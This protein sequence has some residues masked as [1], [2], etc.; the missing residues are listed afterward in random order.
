CEKDKQAEF[1]SK[2]DRFIELLHIVEENVRSGRTHATHGCAQVDGGRVHVDV[3]LSAQKASIDRTALQMTVIVGPPVGVEKTP[4]MASEVKDATVSGEQHRREFN[5]EDMMRELGDD[6]FTSKPV[7]TAISVLASKINIIR[8]VLERMHPGSVS[9]ATEEVAEQRRVAQLEKYRDERND[10][11]IR[12]VEMCASFSNVLFTLIWFTIFVFLDWHH[13]SF[14]YAI[15]ILGGL[16]GTLLLGTYAHENAC[17]ARETRRY[18][19][20]VLFGLFDIAFVVAIPLAASAGVIKIKTLYSTGQVLQGF[21]LLDALATVRFIPFFILIFV[22]SASLSAIGLNSKNKIEERFWTLDRLTKNTIEYERV[23]AF[24][25]IIH[26]VGNIPVIAVIPE[27][28]SIALML[29]SLIAVERIAAFA[30]RGIE[31]HHPSKLIPLICFNSIA[32]IALGVLFTLN[33]F[34]G[35]LAIEFAIAFTSITNLVLTI[36]RWREYG[37]ALP[38]EMNNCP[39]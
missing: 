8:E 12:V 6:S 4:I 5:F 7:K 36:T 19:R 11:H 18:K 3:S 10:R 35:P 9:L 27:A 39:V 38:T 13:F 2:R 20:A 29:V 21:S 37:K 31:Q 1:I 24:W 17:Y 33:P 15:S 26:T 23:Q 30:L 22:V 28:L 32:T 14:T 16:I 25:M 34:G